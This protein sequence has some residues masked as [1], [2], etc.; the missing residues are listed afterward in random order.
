MYR[1][2]LHLARL[3]AAFRL[4][5]R[6]FGSMPRSLRQIV[7][8]DPSTNRLGRPFWTYV[9]A[10]SLFNIGMSI[11]FLLYNLF[12]LDYGYTEV[13][14]G[15]ARSAYSLGGIAGAIPAGILAQKFGL[16]RTM[17][18]C[19]AS[20][21]LLLSLLVLFVSAKAQLGLAFFA[22]A[23][24][25]AWLVCTLPAVAQLTT[26]Q[27]RSRGF[28]VNTAFG[29]G[30]GVVASFVGSR[31]PG[32]LARIAPAATPG[33]LKQGAL[34]VA[35]GVI[36]L[37]VWPASRL[38]LAPGSSPE[39]KFS[40]P[41]PFL[42]RFLAAMA[43][44]SLATNAFTPFFN[45]YCAQ[46]LR[47]PLKEIGWAFSASQLSSMLA[48]LGA[49]VLFRR[50][51]LVTS[52]TVTQVA[53]AGALMCLARIS[54]IPGATAV[55]VIYTGFLWMSEPGMFT[56]LMNRMDPSERNSASSLNLVVMSLSAAVAAPLAGASFARYGYPI[57]LS[58]TAFV[59][60]LAACLFRLLVGREFAQ[61]PQPL[62]D[63]S[64]HPAQ[65]RA[66]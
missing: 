5:G 39:K 23:A 13:F 42:L 27:N 18:V 66:A 44:W 19:L 3:V 61:A 15:Q 65:S 37:A 54:T 26:E 46:Y 25:S 55:Y 53:A 4:L 40:R 31:L 58:A 45:A 17:L 35:C 22:S 24:A 33:R 16:R 29:I 9:A 10:A 28:S 51:G 8:E 63:G 7:G 30:I 1:P 60:L 2:S 64:V 59:T 20:V 32:L 47:M 6:H 52:I 49:S 57:V 21:V 50:F 36:G 14:L 34:L 43:I 38:R 62:Q 48:I 56:L 11:V 41:S 12:L